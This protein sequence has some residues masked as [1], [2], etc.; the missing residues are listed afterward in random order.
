MNFKNKWIALM[1]S[2]ILLLV[3]C[4]LPVSA[5]QL[6]FG[7]VNASGEV[8]AVDALEVLKFAVS[9]ISFTKDQQIAADVDASNGVNAVD[10]LLILQY[11]VDIIQKF[12]A[13]N[14]SIYG[15]EPPKGVVSVP[16]VANASA[17]A[18][19]V[20]PLEID[21]PFNTLT[22]INQNYSA[23]YDL[24][25]QCVLAY[26]YGFDH[27]A[28][29]DAWSNAKKTYGNDTTFGIM[30]AVNRDNG[31]YLTLHPERGMK[32]VQTQYD[33]T[34]VQ[35]S[36]FGDTPVY[37]MVPTDSYIEYK[38]EVI[39]HYLKSG[40]AK[41]V[42]LEE[43]ELWNRSGYS[44]GYKEMYHEYYREDWVDPDTDAEATWK[45]QKLKAWLFKNAFEI[46]SARIKEKYPDVTVLVTSH[47][48]LSYS[49]HGISTGLAMYMSIPTVDGVIGQTWSDDA[50]QYFTYG[51]NQV[52]NVFMNALF[53]YNSYGEA[54][55]DG[56]TLYLLQDPSSDN[57]T[58]TAETKENNW[59][60]TVIAAMMQNDTTSFQSTIWPQRAFQAMGMDYKTIQLN[61]NKMYEEFDSLSGYVYSGTPGI[62]LAASDS[63]G[64]HL[65]ATNVLTGNSQSSIS[66]IYY[67]LQNDGIP[68]DTVYLDNLT[69]KDQLKDVKLLMVSYD[70][71]KP[72][73]ETANQVIA[74]WVKDGGRLLYL[75]GNDGF[76]EIDCEWWGA[77]NT[78]PINDLITQLGLTG[79]TTSVGTVSRGTVPS[80]TGSSFDDTS[81]LNSQYS[82]KTIA[83]SG[84]GFDTFMKADGKNVGVSAN[85]GN[86]KVVFVGLPS[87][88]YS[89]NM[90]NEMVVRELVQYALDG[91][92]TEYS[93]A[94]FFAAQRGDYFA[95]YSS[96]GYNNVPEDKTFVNLFSANLDLVAGG[97]GYVRSEPILYYDVT[98]ENA[99]TIPRVG[100]TGGTE[101]AERIETAEKTEYTIA[102]PS[103]SVPATVI[104]ANGKYPQSVVA[105]TKSGASVSLIT[106]WSDENETLVVKANTPDVTDPITFTITWGDTKVSLPTNYV[107]DGFTHFTTNPNKENDVFLY[108]YS[109]YMNDGCYYCDN[110]TYVTWKVDLTKYLQATLSFDTFGNYVIEVSF[111]G[112]NW[113]VVDDYSTHGK[114]PVGVL[115]D[116]TKIPGD[117]N[118]TNITVSANS[119]AE[120]GNVMYIRLSSCFMNSPE[121]PGG[122]HGGSVY[123]YSL[124][125]LKPAE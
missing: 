6:T 95:Y 65:G 101:M 85:V 48:N 84:S 14:G 58:L 87:A 70:A 76:S 111:D 15:P 83:F 54:L 82:A 32:D 74:Q 19:E 50:S 104:L 103:S 92:G 37:Y 69:S 68:V 42:A 16:Q 98:E 123:S 63:M 25:L 78:T 61:I 45:N 106:S 99:D 44:D 71:I 90:N 66:G 115:P 36:S 29:P 18:T 49:K 8:D 93:P 23:Q 118:R 31:E 35:H 21:E 51:G 91:S 30:V 11:A 64:W 34:Y 27:G 1:L 20:K 47:S 24:D 110:S 2:A 81:S 17:F 12:P 38:W 13:G 116:Q 119:Y 55:N 107:Y 117:A 40:V 39:D 53:A 10:A 108:D 62:A 46:I 67:S 26:V 5:A 28:S 105:N 75:G 125:Y 96:N 122:D 52:S 41:V 22:Q 77:K 59:K 7:D 114:G 56:Q 80:W 89:L 3:A 43:P 72:L 79:M 86:G 57:G 100:F 60:Q 88:F 124:S 121:H 112:Q 109:S 4:V 120:A 9:K 94:K 97:S 113:K 33:G 73:T 102:A